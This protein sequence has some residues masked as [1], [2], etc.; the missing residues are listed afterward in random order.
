[1]LYPAELRALLRIAREI[2]PGPAEAAGNAPLAIGF[3]R[4]WQVCRGARLATERSFRGYEPIQCRRSGR[5]WLVYGFDAIENLAEIA[6]GDLT[7]IVVLQIEPKLGRCAERLAITRQRSMKMGT[8]ALPW[9]YDGLSG[10]IQR[11]A[12]MAAARLKYCASR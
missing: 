2:V 3:G 1:V 6:P 9:R 4:Y 5:L 12:A 8:I 11:C 10:S 7:V